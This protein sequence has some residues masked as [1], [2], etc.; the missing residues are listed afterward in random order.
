MSQKPKVFSVSE[1]LKN[2]NKVSFSELKKQQSGYVSWVNYNLNG[3]LKRVLV[4]APKMFAP[5][6]ATNY[7]PNNV[8]SMNN[9]FQVALS[10]KGEEENHEIAELK[11][12]L[13]KLD[14]LVVDEVMVR[15]GILMDTKKA[16]SRLINKKKVSR[17]TIESAFTTLLKEK[18][19]DEKKFPALFNLKAQVNWK[20]K[21]PYVG[22]KVYD[23]R[24]QKI[25]IN[26]ENYSEVLPKLTDMKCVFQVSSV[27]FI[28][29]KFGLTLKLVQTMIFPS[30]FGVL[31]DCVFDS[32][33][34]E[35]V[36]KEVKALTIEPKKEEEEESEDE[37]E[38]ED[39]EEESEEFIE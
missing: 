7:N 34:E 17:E 24:R 2:L 9:K 20:N 19:D 38:D 15:K 1:L 13:Q 35:E 8:A 14:K 32:E 22:T 23:N 18:D 6:G 21:E 30:N 11:T 29:K 26:F 27:W 10:F 16:W 31:E 25:E 5:F 37:S 4:R 12:L 3:S 28:N 36:V 33:D 39:E